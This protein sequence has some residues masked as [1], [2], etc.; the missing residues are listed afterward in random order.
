[1]DVCR[2]LQDAG[3]AAICVH[4]RTRHMTRQLDGCGAADWQ[5]IGRLVRELEPFPVIANGGISSLSDAE[6]CLAVTGSASVMAAEALLENP[7][8]FVANVDPSNGAY[9]DQDQLAV[10]YLALCEEHP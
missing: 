4:G 8:L 9:L 5:P 10:R 7:A 6:Q 2:R 1:M 3:A